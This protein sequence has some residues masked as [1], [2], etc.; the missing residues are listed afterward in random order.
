MPAGQPST[1]QPIAGPW[2]SPKVVTRKRWPKV[3]NDMGST[4]SAVWYRRCRLGSNEAAAYAAGGTNVIRPGRAGLFVRL[5]H[6]LNI[7]VKPGQEFHQAIDRVFPKVASEHS[8]HFGLTDAHT[9]SCLRL[10]M[11]ALRRQTLDF[12]DD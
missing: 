3:L 8:G 2:L 1:T 6:D 5:N 4:G 9:L 10:R 12:R 11:H 7:S